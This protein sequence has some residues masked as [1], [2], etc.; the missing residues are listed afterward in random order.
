M[1]QETTRN[2][3]SPRDLLEKALASE[4]GVRIWFG[5]Q[6]EAVSM[7]NRMA[8]VKTEERKKSTKIY[9]LDSPLYNTSSYDSLAVI[10][11]PGIL[12]VGEE[13]KKLFSLSPQEAL[14]GVWL[15]ILPQGESEQGFIVEEL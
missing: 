11:K 14:S 2:L 3:V 9:D 4:R 13:V 12:S 10:I 1:S 5:S 7:R 8:T 6:A 15:Y